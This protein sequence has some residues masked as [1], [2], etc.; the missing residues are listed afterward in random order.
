MTSWIKK[1]VLISL[2]KSNAVLV[3]RGFVE[4]RKAD[5]GTP[6]KID[7]ALIVGKD[8]ILLQPFS[9]CKQ[10]ERGKCIIAFA[11]EVDAL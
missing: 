10:N 3:V 5:F 8:E 7:G 1:I 11:V 4:D 6:E 2:Y 9:F